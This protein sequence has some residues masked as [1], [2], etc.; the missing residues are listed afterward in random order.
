MSEARV[1]LHTHST[2]SDGSLAPAELVRAAARREV[3]LLALTDHDTTAGLAEAADQCAAAG[4]RF[5]PGVE[6]TCQWRE[7]EIHV[8]GLAMDAAHPALQDHLRAVLGLR[9]ARLAALCARLDALGLPGS[10]IHTECAALAAPT[11]THVA[12]ALVM[13]GAAADLEEAFERWLGR[14]G[15]AWVRAEWPELAVAV[16]AI[17]AAGGIAVLAHPH[18]YRCSGGQLRELCA[19]FSAAGG[20]AIEVSLAGMGPGD[21]ASACSLA[22]RFDLA[23]SLG[24]DFHDP[25][26]PWR[27]LGRFVKLPEGITPVTALLDCAPRPGS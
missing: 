27:P 11:R 25:G 10:A 17:K 16:G 5:V 3:T 2:A 15:R 8:V 19:A 13:H 18:R 23:G 9:R 21:T 12:R 26:L 20:R 22:R 4:I 14:K 24:S 1:D 7:R 6:A